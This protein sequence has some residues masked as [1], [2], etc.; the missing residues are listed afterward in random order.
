M[1]ANKNSGSKWSFH[2]KM[3][4]AWM[5]VGCESVFVFEI[6]TMA[7]AVAASSS[8]IILSVEIEIKEFNLYD[9][10]FGSSNCIMQIVLRKSLLN[11]KTE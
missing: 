4:E 1:D 5:P 7:I 2:C 10:M 8:L 3:G 6:I 11:F 9:N